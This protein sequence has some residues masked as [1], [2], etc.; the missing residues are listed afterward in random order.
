MT[1]PSYRNVRSFPGYRVGDDGSLWSYLPWRGR[2]AGKWYPLQPS[3]GDQYGHLKVTLTRG[4]KHHQRYVHAL[5]LEAFVGPCPEGCECLHSDGDPTN[6]RLGN[7]RWGTRQE[8]VDDM[9]RHGT[10]FTPFARPPILPPEKIAE[11][12]RRGDAGESTRKLAKEFGVGKDTAHRI[13]ARKGCYAE[14][15]NGMSNV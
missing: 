7:I 15:P 13:I 9:K 2:E 8:N 10:H 5:V 11:M 1:A 14:K 3:K 12:Q 6:N 4:G